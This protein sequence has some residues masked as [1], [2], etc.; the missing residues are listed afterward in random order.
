MAPEAVEL[1]FGAAY[2]ATYAGY[3]DLASNELDRALAIKPGYLERGGWTPNAYLY[4][5]EIDKFLSWLPSDESAY[6]QFYRA[7][8]HIQT[9]EP[10]KAVECS[11][12]CATRIQWMFL[13][14]RPCTRGGALRRAFARPKRRA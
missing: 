5:G 7:W 2:V 6:K 13:P 4:R 10:R 1:H 14:A 3:L 8:S 11:D 9:G 12:A